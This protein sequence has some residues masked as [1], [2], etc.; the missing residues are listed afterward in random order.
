MKTLFAVIRVR[1]AA[2]DASKPLRAQEQWPEHATFM[3]HLAAV[4]F[5]VLG[6]PLGDEGH[7]LLAVD[8]ADEAEIHARLAGDPWSHAGLLE[9]ASIERW[10]ILLEA[11]MEA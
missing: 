5:V 8:A 6:G 1:G 10:T 2:W 3:N 7:V 9:V 11:G 4:G